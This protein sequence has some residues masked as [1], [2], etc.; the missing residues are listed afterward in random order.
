MSNITVSQDGGRG[1]GRSG[2]QPL[3][4]STGDLGFFPGEVTE[5][6]YISKIE[7]ESGG[8]L[9]ISLLWLE[10]VDNE[11]SALAV[12]ISLS[13]SLKIICVNFQSQQHPQRG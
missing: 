2:V 5:K 7:E 13:L 6:L 9:P 3:G 12:N 1:R 8:A 10:C 11:L 4:R